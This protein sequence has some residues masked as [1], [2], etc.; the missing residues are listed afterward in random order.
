ME[1]TTMNFRL[2]IELMR[3]DWADSFKSKQ[4]LLFIIL[5]PFLLVVIMPGFFLTVIAMAPDDDMSL[6]VDIVPPLTSNWE[7]LEEV[8]KMLVVMSIFSQ[9]FILLVPVMISSF[10]AADAIIGE[11][12]RR[13]IEVLLA[14]PMTDQEIL[15]GK[16]LGSII[17]AVVSTWIFAIPHVLIVDILT[18]K[19]L[20]ILLLP[21]LRFILFVSLFTPLLGFITVTFIIMISSRVA[22]T[23]D[24]QQV[25]GILVLPIILLII[26][27]MYLVLF[28][29][30]LIVIGIV[31][32]I[33]FSFIFFKISTNVFNREKLMT[34]E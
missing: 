17:P 15:L 5:L 25:T 21:D 31:I 10:I 23:R 13:T 1:A 19:P 14:L 7:Q 34:A 29:V 32:L 9:F 22:N 26:G 11:K 6:L 20:G 27:Q 16:I 18:Y 8:G 3:K 4:I 2:I 12:E 30:S 24:A 28:D 33:V